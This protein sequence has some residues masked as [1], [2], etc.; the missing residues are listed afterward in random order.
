MP[1]PPRPQPGP[2]RPLRMLLCSDLLWLQA[3]LAVSHA[4][5]TLD[6]SLGPRGPLTGPDYRIGAELGQTHGSNLFHSCE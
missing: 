4:Q 1:R 3:L 5:L 6:G 2:S